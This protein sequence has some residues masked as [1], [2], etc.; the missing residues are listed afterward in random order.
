MVIY[1]SFFHRPSAFAS[2]IKNWCLKA[3]EDRQ[4]VRILNVKGCFHFAF[5]LFN[6]HLKK[7]SSYIDGFWLKISEW[8]GTVNVKISVSIL[9]HL[10]ASLAFLM[11]VD[12]FCGVV[13]VL[14][15]FMS[16]VV[17]IYAAILSPLKKILRRVTDSGH[18]C[19]LPF[20]PA[21]SKRIPKSI[22]RTISLRFLKEESRKGLSLTFPSFFHSSS[23]LY[24]RGKWFITLHCL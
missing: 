17:I 11:N 3:Q 4:R 10:V 22:S 24:A 1:L 9:K 23:A 14:C 8:G 15:C 19:V 6:C 21:N 13:I 2:L 20:R 18:S 12:V 16:A 7:L 5:F